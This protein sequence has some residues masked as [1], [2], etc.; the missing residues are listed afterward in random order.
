MAPAPQSHTTPANNGAISDD[1]KRQR[2]A[3]ATPLA[4]AGD[5]PDRSV[6]VIA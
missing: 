2:A 1:G 5:T 3:M 6:I 4:G